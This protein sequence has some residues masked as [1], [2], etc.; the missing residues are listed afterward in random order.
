MEA[1]AAGPVL[2]APT[3]RLVSAVMVVLGLLTLL[4]D[5]VFFTVWVVAVVL[6]LVLA[7]QHLRMVVLEEGMLPV[8]TLWLILVGAAVALV[9]QVTVVTA[10]AVL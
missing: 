9:A 10:V 2:S 7:G 8:L 6:I 1:A 4:L 5:Q 3:H